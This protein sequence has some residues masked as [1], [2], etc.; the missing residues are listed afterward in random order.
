MK[1]IFYVLALVLLAVPFYGASAQNIKVGIKGGYN[2]AN[3]EGNAMNNFQSIVQLS[4]GY[5]STEMRSGFHA[6]A[7]L[8]V[9]VTSFLTL[10][11]G[12]YYSQK[13][14]RLTGQLSSQTLDFLDVRA[15]LTNRAEYVDVPL[16]AKFFVADGFHIYGGPQMSFLVSNKINVRAGAFGINVLNT[17]INFDNQIRKTDVGLVGGIGYR[18]ANGVNLSGGYDYGLNTVDKGGNLN[19]YN[20]V[21]KVSMGFE[22]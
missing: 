10:E 4:N 8:S 13:G 12:A 16:L 22:F 3:W 17:N 5:V 2:A 15:T 6:G 18:F 1:K 14:I 11:P 21:I 19:T 7:F 9:P 20:R